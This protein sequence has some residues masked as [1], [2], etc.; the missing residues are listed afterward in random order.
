MKV[1]AFSGFFPGFLVIPHKMFQGFGRYQHKNMLTY[2]VTQVSF[3]NTHF[4]NF[5]RSM[6]LILLGFALYLLLILLRFAPFP[7]YFSLSAPYGELDTMHRMLSAPPPFPWATCYCSGSTVWNAEKGRS[8]SLLL[9]RFF[10]QQ[11]PTLPLQSQWRP[12]N[13]YSV[14]YS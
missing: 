7:P 14:G 2:Y 8:A 9:Q 4:L 1:R 3:Q 13:V 6:P 12:R 11:Y 10:V 5:I